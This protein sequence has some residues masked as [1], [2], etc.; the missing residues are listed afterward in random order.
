MRAFPPRPVRC[1]F[2]KP[3]R[4][5]LLSPRC[6][7]NSSRRRAFLRS[8]FAA[9]WPYSGLSSF[10]IGCG[11]SRLADLA[12]GWRTVLSPVVVVVFLMAVCASYDYYRPIAPLLDSIKRAS[13]QI[14]NSPLPR[15][16]RTSASLQT[17]SGCRGRSTGFRVTTR[18]SDAES[19]ATLPR[20]AH[21]SLPSVQP[22]FRQPCFTGRLPDR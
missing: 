17:C 19:P 9:S 16:N 21:D 2:R 4:V 20:E 15:A 6:A 3:F 8:R 12:S 7:A 1:P 11:H 10:R 22:F 18:K 13:E 5:R 14:E